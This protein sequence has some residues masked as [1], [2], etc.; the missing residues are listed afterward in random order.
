M[1]ITFDNNFFKTREK[2][3]AHV[4]KFFLVFLTVQSTTQ[5]SSRNRMRSNWKYNN[6]EMRDL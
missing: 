6:R 4:K 5:N 2:N 1:I 3:K